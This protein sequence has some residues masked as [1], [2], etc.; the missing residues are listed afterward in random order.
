VLLIFI[1]CSGA[2]IINYGY[3]TLIT[4]SIVLQ[5]KSN[6]LHENL[7]TEEFL[8]RCLYFLPVATDV[9]LFFGNFFCQLS[10]SPEE[11]HNGSKGLIQRSLRI[12]LSH[13]CSNSQG[14]VN[15]SIDESEESIM[16]SRD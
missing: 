12:F 15:I 2:N 14:L 4:G 11:Q 1:N 5:R 9:G 13:R 16:G 3:F 8:I 6:E 7:C 10:G